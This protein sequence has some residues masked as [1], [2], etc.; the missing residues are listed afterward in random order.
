[1]GKIAEKMSKEQVKV[2]LTPM[3][4]C[5]FL[6]LI[7]FMIITEITTEHL[8]QLE[9]PKAAAAKP[10]VNRPQNRLILNIVKNEPDNPDVRSG[11]I[12][13]NRTQ[14]PLGD[15]RLLNLLK[16]EADP[17]GNGAARKNRDPKGVS[18]RPLLIRCDRRVQYQ[19]FQQVLMLCAAPGVFI[20][21]IEIAIATDEE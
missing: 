13:I 15:P 20:V 7:F 8:E 21:K 3:I 10:D 12:I 19:Y 11:L 14:Y 5:V 4:D 18:E 17:E 9:L 16:Y 6:L 1:M 2:D